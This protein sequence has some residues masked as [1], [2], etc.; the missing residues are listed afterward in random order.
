MGASGSR[1]IP[2]SDVNVRCWIGLTGGGRRVFS[3][4]LGRLGFGQHGRFEGLRGD[5]GY[6]GFDQDARAI[7]RGLIDR[8][9]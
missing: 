4:T 8:V 5:T 6:P 9:G 7:P 3:G 2:L 1:A